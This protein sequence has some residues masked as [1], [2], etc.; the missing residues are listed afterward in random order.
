MKG[1]R[2]ERNESYEIKQQS[3]TVVKHIQP[4]GQDPGPHSPTL[5]TEGGGGRE[6]GERR[7]EGSEQGG[8]REERDEAG[9]SRMEEGGEGSKEGGEEKVVRREERRR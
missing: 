9:R 4:R 1:W 6:G 3:C 8:R 5:P 2:K 7:G